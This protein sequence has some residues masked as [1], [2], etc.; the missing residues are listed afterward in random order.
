MLA[1]TPVGIHAAHAYIGTHLDAADTY[2][3]SHVHIHL[4]TH[5]GI[6]A[7]YTTIGTH[8]SAQAASTSWTMQ[9]NDFGLQTVIGM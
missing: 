7:A 1:H 5:V 4:P 3:G 2:I 9:A 6:L 8:M